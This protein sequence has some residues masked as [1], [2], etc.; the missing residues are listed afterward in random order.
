MPA[1][2]TPLTIRQ[3][4]LKNRIVVSPMCQYSCEDGMMN[5]WHLVHLGTFAKGGAGLVIFEAA[6]VCPNARISPQ[7][8]GIWKDEQ[9][10]PMKRIVNFIHQ[11]KASAGIQIAHAGRKASTIPPFLD[12]GRGT[13]CQTTGGWKNIDGPSPIS[14]NKEMLVPHE[15]S[16]SEIADKIKQFRD[17]AIRV[18][19]AGFD[20]LEIH[21]AHGY[22]IDSFLSPL[23]N[24][25][26]DEYGGSFEGR[27]KLLIDIA[28]ECR[29][30]WP[31]SKPLFVRISCEEWVDGGWHIDDSARLAALLAPIGVDLLD[32]SSGGN[33][34]SQQINLGP[35][36]QV[37]FS[38][39]I[40][41]VVPNLLTSAVGLISTGDEASAIVADNR[42]DL[43]MLARPFLR[44]PFW[45]L[46]AAESLGID[47]HYCL[48]YS[49]V[50]HI[51]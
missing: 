7:D 27:T 23:S 2:F 9:I 35:L 39:R 48:Q 28:R 17:A 20:V 25:R 6:A 45:P 19:K 16:V 14:W 21:G 40:K 26:T 30:V 3:V 41:S 24:T 10:E 43:V 38:A 50:Q 8:A 37:P 46:R 49:M 18:D 47:V 29:Q 36:Y 22:L 11:F 34:A 42:A 15:L 5:D 12:N 31:A 51:K 44:D 13:A 33:S 32:C 4:E 1:L